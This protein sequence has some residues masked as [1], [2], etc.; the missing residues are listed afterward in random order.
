M[1]ERTEGGDG[2]YDVLETP[3]STITVTGGTLDDETLSFTYGVNPNHT[4]WTL[5]EYLDV[6][7]I[8]LNGLK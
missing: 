5:T 6:L 2:Y 1:T 7:A 3:A 8:T 4:S